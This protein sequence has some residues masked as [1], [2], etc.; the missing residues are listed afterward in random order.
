MPEQ[1]TGKATPELFERVILRHLGAADPAVL[2][3]P[4]HGEDV[5]APAVTA[6]GFEPA[7]GG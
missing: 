6:A 4:Q 3:G 2:V 1:V 5:V 7:L